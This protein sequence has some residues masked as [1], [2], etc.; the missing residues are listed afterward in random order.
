MKVIKLIFKIKNLILNYFQ[1]SILHIYKYGDTINFGNLEYRVS[2]SFLQNTSQGGPNNEIFLLLG[3]SDP[4]EFCEKYYRY[5]PIKKLKVR[6]PMAFPESNEEDYKALSRV[7]V[8]LMKL[9][10]MKNI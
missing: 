8:A 7:V 10:K 2:T 5:K 4:N 9:W 1:K 3:I 6:V